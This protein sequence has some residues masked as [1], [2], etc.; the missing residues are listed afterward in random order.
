V[1]ADRGRS[2]ADGLDRRG[3]WTLLAAATAALVVLALVLVPWD[4]VPGGTLIPARD[5]DVFTT[6]QI[7]RA[8]N[9]ARV[10]RALF[11]SSYAVS[12]VVALLLG[13]TRAGSVLTARLQRLLPGGRW[14][15]A[16]PVVVLV[17]L[18]VGRAV[19]LPFALLVRERRLEVGLTYQSLGG[20]LTDV[21]LSLL[22]SWVT[23]SLLVLLLVGAARRSPRRWFTWAAGIVVAL[24]YLGSL[25]YPVVVE[26]LFN[27]F[28]SMEEGPFKESVLE[29]A[30]AEGVAVDDVLVADASRR[31]TTLNAYVSGIAGTRRV[32]VY[33]NLVED[34]EPAQARSVIA[35]ELAHAKHDDVLVGTSLGAL[36]GV[37]GVCLLALLLDSR[38][39]RRRAGT[40]GPADP[41]GIALVLALVAVGGLVVSPVQNAVSRAIEVRADRSALVATDDDEA[42][43]ELQRQL[44]LRSLADPTPPWLSQL[45]FGSH[46]TVLQRIGLPDS[47]KGVN[48]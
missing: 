41:R 2:A 7:A 3:A 29:L 11:W 44:A 23:T 21:G 48:G 28:T 31:T 4:W 22:V 1:G 46:P 42:F 20:W 38:S 10:M 18:L 43:R 17:L 33:D 39:L 12:L 37:A 34:L 8:E 35:H 19:T 16:G 45:W 47:M 15:L 13:L 36:S 6:A 25:G 5:V 32:V 24:S 27:R 40:D 9:H 26:P 30:E 14:W